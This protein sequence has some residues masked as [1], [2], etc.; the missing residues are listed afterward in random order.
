MIFSRPRQVDS[1]N[2]MF[3]FEVLE[4]CCWLGRFPWRGA[5]PPDHVTWRHCA[6]TCSPRPRPLSPEN[7]DFGRKNS[8]FF[9]IGK[10]G[11]FNWIEV[12]EIIVKSFPEFFFGICFDWFL[13]VGLISILCG[14]V[15]DFSNN[16]PSF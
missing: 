12:N 10:F 3:R 14:S 7:R 4:M 8:I 11:H 6:V 2:I 1:N 13:S 15:V 5:E 16:I 9:V